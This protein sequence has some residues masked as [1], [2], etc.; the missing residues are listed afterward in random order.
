MQSISLTSR[1]TLTYTLGSSDVTFFLCSGTPNFLTVVFLLPMGMRMESDLIRTYSRCHLCVSSTLSF[2]SSG[3]LSALVG[4]F[5]QNHV[6]LLTW[7][8]GRAPQGL[9]AAVSSVI[10]YQAGTYSGA[11]VTICLSDSFGSEY[12]LSS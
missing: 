12:T 4:S 1:Q 10:F 6:E 2:I 8:I 7:A 9:L 5:L 3:L 11:F